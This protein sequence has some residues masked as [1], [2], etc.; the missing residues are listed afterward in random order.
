M[1]H[2]R[3]QLGLFAL[4]TLFGTLGFAAEG[5]AFRVDRGRVETLVPLKPGGA[6]TASSTAMGGTL[7]LVTGKPVLLNGEVW[8]DLATIDTGIALRSQHLREKYLEV[9]KGAGYDKAVLSAIRLND[10]DGEGFEGRTGFMATLL[11]HDVKKP[12][13]GTAEIRRDGASRRVQAE[14]K[15]SLTDFGVEPPEYLGVGVGNTL[16]VKVQFAATPAA[17]K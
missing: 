14:F 12:V 16:L 2:V 17:G 10:A 6:F 3:R 4:L 8:L 7:T 5:P 11:L 15:L 9:A 1:A 13:E